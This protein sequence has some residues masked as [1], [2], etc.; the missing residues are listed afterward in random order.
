MRCGSCSGPCQ[1]LLQHTLTG[2][3]G[4]HLQEAKQRKR[5]L[6]KRLLCCFS[7]C[8]S[9]SKEGTQPPSQVH[10]LE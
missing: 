10:L 4:A 1:A 8:S 6:L 5:S 3:G 7:C 9:N 2:T